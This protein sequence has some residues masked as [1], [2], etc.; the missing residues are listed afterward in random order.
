MN[1]HYA[2]LAADLERA[3]GNDIPQGITQLCQKAADEIRRLCAAEQNKAEQ[4]LKL[5]SHDEYLGD[6]LFARLDDQSAVWLGG[7]YYV[8]LEPEV[9][10]EF[11]YWLKQV[12][13]LSS[14]RI[15]S[16]FKI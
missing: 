4:I 8:V 7:D 14:Y 10:A 1:K 12:G 6:G 5:L 2:Q 16:A 3:Y 13:V 11:M 9:L 15:N